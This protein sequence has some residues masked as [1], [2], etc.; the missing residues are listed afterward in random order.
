MDVALKKYPNEKFAE[1]TATP[2]DIKPILRGIWFD[3]D[4]LLSEQPNEEDGGVPALNLNSTISSAHDILF[5]V[6]KDDPRGPTPANPAHDPQF[7]LW[8]YPVSLW[9]ESILLGT[10]TPAHSERSQDDED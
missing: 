4:S 5:Y 1:P 8:E 7:A 6:Q 9:K 3:T 2:Q 10:S